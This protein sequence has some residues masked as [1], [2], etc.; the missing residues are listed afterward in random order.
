MEFSK[1]EE[2]S[3]SFME[4]YKDDEQFLILLNTKW[5]LDIGCSKYMTKD[6]TLFSYFTPKKR[7]ICLL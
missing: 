6:K 7:S 5:Y 4:N 3:I 2:A 1:D